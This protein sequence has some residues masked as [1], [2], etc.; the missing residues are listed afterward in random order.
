VKGGV[1]TDI[2]GG[3]AGVFVC[4]LTVGCVGDGVDVAMTKGKLKVLQLQASRMNIIR[5]KERITFGFI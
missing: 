1:F 4:W 3:G 5:V 2:E